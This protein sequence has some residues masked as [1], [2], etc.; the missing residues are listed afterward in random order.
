[1][2]KQN[3]FFLISFIPAIAYW[4]LEANYSLK[5]A[6]IGGLS[7]GTAEIIFEKLFFKH[8]HKISKLNFILIAFLGT[9]SLLGE[10][11]LWFKMQPFFTGLVMS[12]YLFYKKYKGESLLVEMSAEIGQKGLPDAFVKMMEFHMG[13]F[14]LGYGTFMLGI[15]LTQET[16]IWL[17]WKSGGFYIVM[18]IFFIMDILYIKRKIPLK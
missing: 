6:L 13:F 11:G 3:K 2:N 7:L 12:S 18:I 15:A 8:I 5:I 16:S 14:L 10:D 4:Y 17:F 1:M 9:I